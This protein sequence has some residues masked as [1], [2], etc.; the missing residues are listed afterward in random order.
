LSIPIS[1]LKKRR[2]NY[3]HS[4]GFLF[5]EKAKRPIDIKDPNKKENSEYSDEQIATALKNWTPLYF[6]N[7]IA[8]QDASAD[9]K[10]K[11]KVNSSQKKIDKD[12]QEYAKLTG[13]SYKRT[14]SDSKTITSTNKGGIKSA[15]KSAETILKVIPKA[16]YLQKKNYVE[17]IPKCNNYNT[18][19]ITASTSSLNTSNIFAANDHDGKLS[20]FIQKSKL[21]TPSNTSFVGYS[22]LLDTQ[23]AGIKSQSLILEQERDVYENRLALQKRQKKWHDYKDQSFY[24]QLENDKKIENNKIEISLK[25][26]NDDYVMNRQRSMAMTQI[27]IEQNIV[28]TTVFNQGLSK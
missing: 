19:T 28:Q 5:T 8:A 15:K 9:E 14:K 3:L 25:Q 20:S 27:E 10:S 18:K 23:L 22:E 2:D 17:Q 21:E 11:R 12:L 26:R 24:D 7:V 1:D 16:S 4:K 13:S 6:D